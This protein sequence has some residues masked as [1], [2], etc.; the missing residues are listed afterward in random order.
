MCYVFITINN[1]E[2]SSEVPLEVLGL[3]SEY[4]DVIS[5]NFLKGLPLIR[6]ISYQ[7]YLVLGASFPNKA[8]HKMTPTETNELNR[9]QELLSKCL[10]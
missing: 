2:G 9:V 8:A 10:I 6:Q 7:I 3:L 4:G 1:N 5:N